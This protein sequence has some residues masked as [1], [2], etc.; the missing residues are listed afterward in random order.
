MYLDEKRFHLSDVDGGAGL[1]ALTGGV[2]GEGPVGLTVFNLPLGEL[3]AK[4]RGT[5]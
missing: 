2:R 5:P 4:G 1:E 3:L